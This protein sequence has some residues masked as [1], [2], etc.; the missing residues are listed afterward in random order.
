MLSQ[1]TYKLFIRLCC[2]VSASLLHEGHRFAEGTN[3]GFSQVFSE[4]VSRPWHVHFISC[5]PNTRV[6]GSLWVPVSSRGFLLHFLLLRLSCLSLS[7]VFI[8]GGHEQY[9][10]LNLSTNVA[11]WK[12][13]LACGGQWKG[14]NKCQVLCWF[15][16][17]LQTYKNA[18]PQY[19]K[20]N[21]QISPLEPAVCPGN[22]GFHPLFTITMLV[23]GTW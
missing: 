4:Q 23:N 16:K 9:T 22:S 19:F 6:C 7:A 1:S 14:Q 18:K 5:C 20:N 13:A 2:F 8:P 17:E 10:T 3:R 21:I 15:L 11:A 12:A